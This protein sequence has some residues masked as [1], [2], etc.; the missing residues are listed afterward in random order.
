MNKGFWLAT[1]AGMFMIASVS[2]ATAASIGNFSFEQPATGSFIYDPVDPTLSWN[3]V[4]RSG[5][6]ANTFFVPPPPDGTQ[7][8]FIQQFVDQAS[9]LSMITQQL[10]G[11]ALVPTVL[12]FEIAERPG[13][14]PNPIVVMYGTQNLGTFA[15]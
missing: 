12:T 3:F 1:M 8:A 5:V 11:V 9:S 10:S 15:P 14:T 13:Y 2:K 7:A 4:G 6:A